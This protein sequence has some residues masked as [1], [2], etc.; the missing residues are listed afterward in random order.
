MTRVALRGLAQRPLRTFL[1][2]LAIVLGVA[3]VSAA[4][5]V[6]D[7]MRSAADSLSTAAYHGTD[8][9]VAAPVKFTDPDADIGGSKTV[10]ASTL[11]RVRAVPGVATATGDVLEQAKIVGRDG[12]PVGTGPYFGAGYDPSVPGAQ[13]LTPF[14]LS[15]GRWASG[16]GEVVVD[17]S[18]A[19]KQHLAIGDQVRVATMGPVRSFRLVGI[20]RFGSVDRLGTATTAIFD[21]ST[22]QA[23]FG[24]RGAFDTVLVAGKPGVSPA[25]L[26]ANLRSALGPGLQV[27]SAEAQDRFT[28]NELKSFI[29][30]LRTILLAMGGVAIVVG[31]FTIFNALAITIAQRSRELALVR[32]LGAGRGQ[33]LRSV[34]VEALVIALVASAAGVL[35]GLALAKGIDAL[36]TASGVSLPT[37]AMHLAASTVLVAVL[38]GTLTTLIAG[39]VPA[40]RATRVAPV[41]VMREGGAEEHAKLS[42]RSAVIAAGAF[43]LGLAALAYGLFAS[44][45]SVGERF[46]ALVPGCLVLLLG[47]AAGSPRAV[48][49]ITAVVG[50]PSRRLGG[51]AGRLA[52]RN[53]TRNPG[54]TAATAAA[55]M[56]GLALVTFVSVLGSGIKASTTGKLE[57]SVRAQFVLVGTDG[58]STI[59]P[60]SATAVGKLPGVRSVAGLRERPIEVFGQRTQI[61]GVPPAAFANAYRMSFAEGSQST[62]ASLSGP[63]ASVGQDFARKHHL[64]V[65]SR[66][67][68]TTQNA[69]RVTLTVRAIESR[70][71]I[72][73]LGRAPIT[74]AAGTFDK[75]FPPTDARMTFVSTNGSV[76][77][78]TVN[79]AVAQ[80][81]GTKAQTPKA[82]AK[83]QAGQIDQLLAVLYVLLALAVVVS[84][85]GIVTT[86]ALSVVER[87]REIGVLRAVGATRRQVR[88]S[89]RHEGVVV[90]LIGAI[91]G[92]AV[93]LVLAALTTA[94]L[95]SDGMQFSVPVGSLVAF[96]FV[97]CIAGVLAAVLPARRASRLDVLTALA[98]Q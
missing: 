31:A 36:F 86:L 57:H 78:S 72:E 68:V 95:A 97:A 22:A 3:M 89:V 23:L 96:A 66:F 21:L 2:S 54:R 42:R 35:V 16:P 88:R 27:R 91:L 69:R 93:G 9:V 13:G 85:F 38:V 82:Y 44:G 65:G 40:L 39:L 18:T 15:S 84:L 19:S 62:F 76:P 32:A 77:A 52:S 48:G 1:T 79:G 14:R 11:A 45:L 50:W 6:T 80:F 71:A 46:T 59:D 12:K 98:Y 24:R 41:A 34:T 51:V 29:S 83:D 25:T 17:P 64:K 43:G 60:A 5:T 30:I 33:V 75:A 28:L 67:T 63:G 92:M 73:P 94:A 87:T 56:V 37:T 70:P 20:A 47:V 10:A 61:D 58:W 8:A 74:I 26:R 7:T 55:L 53:A 90:A 81:P 4:L 49:P